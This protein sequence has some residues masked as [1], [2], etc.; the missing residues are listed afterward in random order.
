MAPDPQPHWLVVGSGGLLGSSIMRHLRRRQ[1][2]LTF[3]QITWRYPEQ[4]RSQLTNCAEDFIARVGSDPWRVVWAAGAGVVSSPREELE[5]ETLFL[6]TFLTALQGLAGPG[7]TL[8][9]SSA[10]ALYAGSTR[11]PFTEDH[12]TFPLV[13]YGAAK[14]EQEALASHFVPQAGRLVVCRFANLYGPGQDLNK[15][16]GIVTK[17]AL[18]VITKRPLP[19]HVPLDTL[20]DFIYVDDASAVALAALERVAQEPP[21]TAVCKI[22]SSGRTLNLTQV[23]GDLGR[24]TRRTVPVIYGAKAGSNG[25]AD[26]L[27]LHSIVWPELETLVSTPFVVGMA[28]TIADL[29]HRL[30]RGNAR[31]KTVSR[32]GSRLGSKV[33]SK[34]GSELGSKLGLLP[35]QR[36]GDFSGPSFGGN[37]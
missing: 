7:A 25:Q 20:R 24:A 8:M 2:D 23:L 34:P 37:T 36:A 35:E 29:E 21:K 18:A 13:H 6:R 28:A 4:A 22:V 26:D 17:A 27:R 15:P 10:G 12:A 16:Q 3:A 14:K 33:G 31:G 1:A 32:P 30:A 5:L 9:A 19:L 11:P